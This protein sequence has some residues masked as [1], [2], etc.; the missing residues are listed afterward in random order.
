[1]IAGECLL[2]VEGEERRAEALGLLP[3]SAVTEH[4]LIGAGKHGCTVSGSGAR[5]TREIVYPVSESLSAPA[6]VARRRTIHWEAYAFC[7]NLMRR[8]YEE[9]WLGDPAAPTLALT[10]TLTI[11][12][13]LATPPL[14]WLR[15][16]RAVHRDRGSS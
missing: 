11:A 10:C 6:G 3:L 1:V 5:V 16:A 13:D 14:R 9:E 15:R 12:H 2:L 8:F 7:D 4:I